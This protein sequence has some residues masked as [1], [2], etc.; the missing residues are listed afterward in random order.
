MEKDDLHI[1][2]GINLSRKFINPRGKKNQIIRAE[3]AEAASRKARVKVVGGDSDDVKTTP[4]TIIIEKENDRIA[5]IIVKCPC[6]RH[7]DLVC[8]YV[9]NDED[10]VEPEHGS[11]SNNSMA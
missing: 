9:D 5:R 4:P 11:H 10:D 1:I 2:S 7:S 6:G 8:E 3:E